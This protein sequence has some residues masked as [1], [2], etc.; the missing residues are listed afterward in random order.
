[1]KNNNLLLFIT[2][3]SIVALTSCSQKGTVVLNNL[4]NDTTIMIPIKW[5]TADPTNIILNIKGYADDTC[6]INEYIF[7]PKGNINMTINIDTYDN[8]HFEFYYKKYKSKN[9]SLKIEYLFP[10]YFF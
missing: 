7:L 8:K 2:L 4:K 9:T 5:I 1:M 10:G 3:F 6:K